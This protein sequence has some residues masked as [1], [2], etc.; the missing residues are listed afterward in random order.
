MWCEGEKFIIFLKIL[1]NS[2]NLKGDHR[3]HL[4]ALRFTKWTP[5]ET[6]TYLE[7]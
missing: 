3:K 7:K 2:L 6:F 4:T 1:F 5:I